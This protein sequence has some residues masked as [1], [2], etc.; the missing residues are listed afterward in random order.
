MSLLPIAWFSQAFDLMFV[1]MMNIYLKV[2]IALVCASALT[3]CA[4]SKIIRDHEYDPTMHA[5]KKGQYKDSIEVFPKKEQG[6]FI[7]SIEQGWIGFWNGDRAEPRALQKQIKSFED[8]K[9][10]SV[11]REAGYF[12]YQESEEGYVPSEHEVVVL[13]LL[14][15]MAFMRAEKFEEAKVEARRAGYYLQ[16]MFNENQ[17]HF[18]DPSL[19]VWLGSIWAALGQWPEAQVDFRK[20]YELS[21]DKR[22]LPYLN[23]VRAP[24]G[25]TLLMYGVAPEIHWKD[26]SPVPEFKSVY[27]DLNPEY[28]AKLKGNIMFPTYGWYQR[29]NLRN[30]ALRDTLLKSNYMAQFMGTESAAATQKFGNNIF[31]T[32]A[33]I[34]AV[35]VGGVII[36]VGF[37]VGAA[38]NSAEAAVAIAGLGWAAGS[39]MWNS[40]EKMRKQNNKSINESR[41]NSLRELRTYRL[42]RFMPAYIGVSFSGDG[43]D[44]YK[45]T[46]LVELQAPESK[47]RVAFVH[48]VQ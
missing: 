3:G 38:G 31:A 24:E 27:N 26:S 1:S 21:G 8:R 35:A 47:T 42:V 13:H 43:K 10:I 44:S 37:Y 17:P 30:T 19:R 22:L 29:H 41:E 2:A 33:K 36:G 20:A 25:V 9:F 6:G 5:F 34:A 28:F 16:G 18:D 48:V 45:P 7:T 15:A 4:N 12:F 23:S 40:A 46:A 39:S 32:S 11:S 14:S